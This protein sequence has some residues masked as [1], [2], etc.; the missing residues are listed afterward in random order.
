MKKRVNNRVMTRFVGACIAFLVV[1]WYSFRFAE[2][3]YVRNSSTTKE[4]LTTKLKKDI[5]G[6]FNAQ[7]GVETKNVII[8]IVTSTDATTS[9]LL[10]VSLIMMSS[11][12]VLPSK[13]AIFVVRK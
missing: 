3:F 5:A 11:D 6:D 4:F 13:M 8:I 12:D 9:S 2:A 7:K 1:S 10:I